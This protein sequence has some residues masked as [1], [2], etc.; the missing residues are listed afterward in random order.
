MGFNM[1]ANLAFG[2]SGSSNAT[3]DANGLAQANV[4][5]Y[6]VTLNSEGVIVDCKIDAIQCK[7]NFD[8]A[9]QLVTESAPNT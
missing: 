8:A 6:A 2:H 5:I 4:D 3:A 1:V 7:V 9:G